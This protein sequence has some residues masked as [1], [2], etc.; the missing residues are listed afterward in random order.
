[1]ICAAVLMMASRVELD[2]AAMRFVLEHG[3]GPRGMQTVPIDILQD[4][5]Q[6]RVA[7]VL[8][9]VPPPRPRDVR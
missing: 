4:L 9:T 3:R 1:M 6:G 2:A 5:L 8:R 7:G